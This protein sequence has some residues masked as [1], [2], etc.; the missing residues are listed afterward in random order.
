M[1]KKTYIR[2]VGLAGIGAIIG[3]MI[4]G[5]FNRVFEDGGLNL[6]LIYENFMLK[7]FM[8]I[9]GAVFLCLLLPAIVF[10][11]KAKKQ[12]KSLDS[13]DED[14]IDEVE[15][16]CKKWINST[17][18]LNL[19]HLIIT[20]VIF[21]LALNVEVSINYMFIGMAYLIVTL[22]AM[23]VIEYTAI[24]TLQKYDTRL[25]GDPSKFS[26][27]KEYFESLDEAEQL[28]VFK[29]AYHGFQVSKNVGLAVFIFAV[30]ITMK[31]DVGVWPV[32]L[33]AIMLLTQLI[34][35]SVHAMTKN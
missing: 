26:Y 25:K 35:Y 23:V 18:I 10:L 24:G 15:D 4:S 28:E 17:I 22:V 16:K 27:S 13:V 7:Y 3:L 30:L 9:Q 11:L 33:T 12:Y 19:S 5:F 6:K 14:K 20:F 21:S 31:F 34:S 1:N 2:T 32:L 8:V 29:S